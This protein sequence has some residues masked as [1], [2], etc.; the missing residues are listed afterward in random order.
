MP[1]GLGDRTVFGIAMEQRQSH[2]DLIIF[3]MIG[4]P[5]VVNSSQPLAMS[6]QGVSS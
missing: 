4:F 1:E 6:K 5:R 3:R 2:L